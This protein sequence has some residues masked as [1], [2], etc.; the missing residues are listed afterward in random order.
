MLFTFKELSQI[1]ELDERKE[2]ID[3]LC[4]E[5]VYSSV[6]KYIGFDIEEKN[7][8]ELHTVIDG[9]ILIDQIN[10]KRVLAIIDQ[11]TKERIKNYVVDYKKKSITFLSCRYDGHVVLINYNS[12]F[13]KKNSPPEI[14]KAFIDLFLTERNNYYKRLKGEECSDEEMKLIMQKYLGEYSRKCL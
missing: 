8:N 1:L 13:C 10:I 4:F 14:K 9:R 6:L 5:S 12:G 2:D 7:H 3:R 11:N